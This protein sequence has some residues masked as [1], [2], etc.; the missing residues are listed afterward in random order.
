M[1]GTAGGPGEG[2]VRASPLYLRPLEKLEHPK[3][4]A[5]VGEAPSEHQTQAKK[6]ERDPGG[7]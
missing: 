3:G 2:C 6:K 1:S 4:D 5:R 7:S